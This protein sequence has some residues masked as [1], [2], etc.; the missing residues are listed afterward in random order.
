[1]THKYLTQIRTIPNYHEDQSDLAKTWRSINYTFKSAS[2]LLIKN[3]KTRIITSVLAVYMILTSGFVVAFI[4]VENNQA[5]AQ[6]VPPTSNL[7]ISIKKQKIE[8][9]KITVK[10]EIQNKTSQTIV[11][12]NFK[13]Q[14]SFDNVAWL[15]SNNDLNNNKVDPQSEVFKLANVGPSQKVS[16]SVYGQLKN[17]DVSNIAINTKV[18]YYTENKSQ[19]ISSPK[20]LIDLK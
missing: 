6:S 7:E 4:N 18:L 17:P 16:Y 15:T 13:F 3:K 5:N 1:M 20:F 10:L 11:N 9:G 12:P 19:E 8:A 14:S 2:N